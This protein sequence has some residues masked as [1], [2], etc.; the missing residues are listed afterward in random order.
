MTTL[1]LTLALAPPLPRP[2]NKKLAATKQAVITLM[3][4]T[5]TTM[6][7]DR[8]EVDL[9]IL[10]QAARLKTPAA[11]PTPARPRLHRGVDERQASTKINGSS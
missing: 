4:V 1:T 7:E 8:Q 5:R 6:E 9:P 11:T 2:A 10:E 3:A